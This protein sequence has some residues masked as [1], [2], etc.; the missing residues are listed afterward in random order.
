MVGGDAL[1]W[2]WFDGSAITSVCIPLSCDMPNFVSVIGILSKS[3]KIGLYCIWC[4]AAVYRHRHQPPELLWGCK[5]W[6]VCTVYLSFPTVIT[7]TLRQLKC[8]EIVHQ[9]VPR[10]RIPANSVVVGGVANDISAR[11]LA[12]WWSN[13]ISFYSGISIFIVSINLMFSF[14]LFCCFVSHTFSRSII[15]TPIQSM[16]KVCT[17][18]LR[19]LTR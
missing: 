15:A 1:H 4:Y 7:K 19:C 17:H 12:R 5:F 2:N 18:L 11:R 9:V 3:S 8:A 13:T 10:K 14:L 16:C 6:N